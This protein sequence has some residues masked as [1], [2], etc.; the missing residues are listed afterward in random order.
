[1]NQLVESIPEPA[2]VTTE[3]ANDHKEKKKKPK[4]GNHGGDHDGGD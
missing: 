4:H 1:V 2:P 3:P